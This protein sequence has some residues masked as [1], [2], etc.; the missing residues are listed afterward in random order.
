MSL[1]PAAAFRW[2]RTGDD[3]YAAMLDAIETET[4]SVRLETYIFTASPLGERFRDAL[5]RAQKRGVKVRLL[6]DAWGSM[7]LPKDF[8]TPLTEAGGE[9]R[10][11]NP[12]EL[13]R[14]VIRNH[15]KL[16]VCGRHT[17][18]VG[19]FN[20]APEYE[21]DGVTRG[22][23][24]QGLRITGPLAQ[25]LA[26]SFDLF[27]SRADFRHPR[28]AR[29][30]K[31]SLPSRL[32][33]PQGDILIG[34]PSRG[35]NA[36]KHSLAVD[37]APARH[38]QIMAAYFLPTWPIRRALARVV[39]RGGQVQLLLA[40]QSDVP[41]SQLACQ[42]LYQRLLRAGMEIYEY[43]PQ[44][45]HAKLVVIDDIV[46]IGSANLDTRSLDINYE[47]LV[48]L[49]NL[50]LASEARAMF[51]EDLTRSRRIDPAVWRKARSFWQRLKE[52]WAYFLLAHVDPFIARRQLKRL[53]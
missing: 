33:A 43:Q 6:I 50:K 38:V 29:L 40:G 7:D 20:I 21:G 24:D 18:F 2:L 22:W 35:R 47:L 32:Q 31:S 42:G 25:K 28:F 52:R 3:A 46:Y 49:P 1:T 9:L 16:L 11:F 13:K 44:V 48:R 15:R 34:R 53:R 14:F 30:L 10:W 17:A 41:L 23:R 39:R 26:E 36:I 19:G 12:L 27:F 8:W 4:D 51:A 45:L 5:V 37:L